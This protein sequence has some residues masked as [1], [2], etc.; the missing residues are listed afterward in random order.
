MKR[1]ISIYLC[2]CTF[3]L[4]AGERFVIP[5]RENTGVYKAKIRKL[6]ERPLFLVGPS[7]RLQVIETAKDFYQVHDTNMRQGWIEKQSCVI[8]AANTRIEFEAALVEKYIDN[9][10]PVTIFGSE[11]QEQTGILLNRSFK[12][13][14]LEN[15][16]KELMERSIKDAM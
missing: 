2:L 3:T 13:A 5:V 4:M 16:D 10:E 14:L 8:A 11:E 9:P 6:Y 15:V 12:D 7:D 1:L